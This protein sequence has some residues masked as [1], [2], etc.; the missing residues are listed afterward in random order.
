MLPT[1]CNQCQSPH[2][3]NHMDRVA[4]IPPR[5]L[6]SAERSALIA[7]VDSL[8]WCRMSYEDG[9]NDPG[10]IR[11]ARRAMNN[12]AGTLDPNPTF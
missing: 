3:C 8:G 4:Y 1:F 5:E 10:L 6:R 2:P 9:T 12:I 11:L 7:M